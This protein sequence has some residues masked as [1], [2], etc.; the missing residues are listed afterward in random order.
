MKQHL[1]Q[2][3]SL[4]RQRLTWLTSESRRSFG[5]VVESVLIVVLDISAAPNE[6]LDNCRRVVQQVLQQQFHH[7]SQ[8]NIV[9]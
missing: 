4:F 6:Q 9:R 7:V 8:F 2:L 3:L 1:T 5:V